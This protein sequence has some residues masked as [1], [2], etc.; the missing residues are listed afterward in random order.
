MYNRNSGNMIDAD[1]QVSLQ[2]VPPLFHPY[3]FLFENTRI[4]RKKRTMKEVGRI[5]DINVYYDTRMMYNK[6]WVLI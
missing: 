5:L 2:L 3:L 6:E 4:V 1:R